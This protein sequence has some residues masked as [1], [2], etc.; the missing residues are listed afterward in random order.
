MEGF[1][2]NLPMQRSSLAVAITSDAMAVW[3]AATPQP[4]PQ[5]RQVY[6]CSVLAT[7]N[8]LRKREGLHTLP[9][10][11]TS[12][13]GLLIPSP[14]AFFASVSL[15]VKALPL[16][17]GAVPPNLAIQRALTKHNL[18]ARHVKALGFAAA[19]NAPLYE[20]RWERDF[21]EY[22]LD[23]TN[24]FLSQL[25]PVLAHSTI[26]F[27][28]HIHA[29]FI[30]R[31]ARRLAARAS[32]QAYP[33][34]RRADPGVPTRWPPQAG[35]VARAARPCWQPVRRVRVARSAPPVQKRPIETDAHHLEGCLHERC[36][37]LL[38]GLRFLHL[39][40]FRLERAR[41]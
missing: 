7:A 39:Y 4:A 20:K 2:K 13:L 30:E 24:S 36:R 27:T 8:T 9:P 18:T 1:L 32:R 10:I 5:A 41:A 40:L 11:A 33:L 37:L 34:I 15:I 29:D 23:D 6:V 31:P 16:P 22:T 14:D 28:H 35:G 21:D 17:P 12:E 25:D 38:A 26:T 19:L 3:D